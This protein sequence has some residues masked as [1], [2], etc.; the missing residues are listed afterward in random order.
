MRKL[1]A[2]L[3]ILPM[4]MVGGVWRATPALAC[5][6]GNNCYHPFVD[7]YPFG[8][9]PLQAAT[10]RLSTYFRDHAPWEARAVDA[11]VEIN[12]ATSSNFNLSFYGQN[13]SGNGSNWEAYDT[14]NQI[15]GLPWSGIDAD[16]DVVVDTN[17]AGNSNTLG[18]GLAV[19]CNGSNQFNHGLVVINGDNPQWN[20]GVSWD[21]S[22]FD[23]QGVLTHELVHATGW[24]PDHWG[25]FDNQVCSENLTERSTMCWKQ[26]EGSSPWFRTLEHNDI[27]EMS[28]A[29][30]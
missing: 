26:S 8:R 20:H 17:W 18:F 25:V 10:V 23:L 12:A 3:C 29:G 1:L 27:Q 28:E 13:Y 22:Q 14:A 7:G 21:T 9:W 2:L 30:Y 15:C 6:A 24:R 16:I 5:T 4:L 11:K 19:K